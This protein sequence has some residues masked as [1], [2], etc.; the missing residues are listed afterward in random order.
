[1]TNNELDEYL[2]AIERKI[3]DWKYDVKLSGKEEEM[4]Q[5]ILREYERLAK[6]LFTYQT[7][8]IKPQ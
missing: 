7:K 4:L 5:D 2:W 8:E 3:T 1:M 6:K